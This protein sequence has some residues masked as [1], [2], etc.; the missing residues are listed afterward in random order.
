MTLEAPGGFELGTLGLG[1]QCLNRLV[2]KTY[3][4][5]LMQAGMQAN[6]FTSAI[7]CAGNI[8]NL[9]KYRAGKSFFLCQDSKET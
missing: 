4:I 5:A 9:T 6:Q 1:I 2:N 8:T 3:A 7:D